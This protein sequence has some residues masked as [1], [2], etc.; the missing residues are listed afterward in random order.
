MRE[1]R[2]EVTLVDDEQLHLGI[3][4]AKLADLLI[5]LGDESLLEHSEFDEQRGVG[6]IEVG[7]KSAN[8]RPASSQAS[9]NSRGS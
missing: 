8:S 6:K 9:G 3:E 2:D 4:G 5:L 7:T 1:Q